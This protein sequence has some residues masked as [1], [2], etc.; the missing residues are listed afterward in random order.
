MS[1]LKQKRVRNDIKG[2]FKNLLFK[3]WNFYMKL[4]FKL[5][6][7]RKQYQPLLNAFLTLSL[8]SLYICNLNYI[9]SKLYKWKFFSS[10]GYMH[11]L[12]FVQLHTI[13]SPLALIYAR[14][15]QIY[16]I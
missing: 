15:E 14:K 3:C 12:E 2:Q 5:F 1:A 13:Y 9:Y 10:H 7:L 8:L 11:L 6:E 16:I 4:S